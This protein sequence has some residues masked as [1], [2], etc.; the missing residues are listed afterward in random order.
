MVHGAHGAAIP[1][2]FSSRKSVWLMP[3]EVDL[4]V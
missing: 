3:W 1:T 4:W 2:L